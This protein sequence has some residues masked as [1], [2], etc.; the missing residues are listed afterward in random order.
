MY[1][2]MRGW[3]PAWRPPLAIKGHMYL[4]MSTEAHTY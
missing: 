1:L 4:G 2:G 3:I